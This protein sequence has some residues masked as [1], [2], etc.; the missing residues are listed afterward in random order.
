MILGSHVVRGRG[1][2]STLSGGFEALGRPV[3]R[4]GLPPGSAFPVRRRAPCLV[5]SPASRV[6][7]PAVLVY[8]SMAA[9]D[10]DDGLEGS[11]GGSRLTIFWSL[12]SEPLGKGVWSAL[13]VAFDK[14]DAWLFRSA[15]MART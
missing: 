14:R 6:K 12:L 2:V 9:G 15:L 3:L 4:G 10:R 13:A 11:G 5:A 7:N 8:L 1:R